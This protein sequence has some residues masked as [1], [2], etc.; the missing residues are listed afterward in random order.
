MQM[1][2]KEHKS[3]VCDMYRTLSPFL[4]SLTNHHLEAAC[5]SVMRGK[6]TLKSVLRSLLK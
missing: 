5:T 3:K 4:Y 6:R 2:A 1:A